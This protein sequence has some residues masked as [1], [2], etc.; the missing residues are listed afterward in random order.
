M[1]NIH[2]IFFNLR[3]SAWGEMT[4]CLK[5]LA[6]FNQVLNGDFQLTIIYDPVDQEL[7]SGLHVH[8]HLCEHLNANM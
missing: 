7:S 4:Q 5:V 2:S 6:S 8:L 1:L 3:I